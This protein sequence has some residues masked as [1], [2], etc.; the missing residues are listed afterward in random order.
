MSCVE[1]LLDWVFYMEIK[2][3]FGNAV[4]EFV[5]AP[6]GE[7][8]EARL[9]VKEDDKSVLFL[10][11]WVQVHD[12]LAALENKEKFTVEAGSLLWNGETLFVEQGGCS[13]EIPMNEEE[14]GMFGQLAFYRSIDPY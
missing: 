2:H 5:P 7:N 12:I 13:I 6:F 9:S 4:I 1:G 3:G 10:L 14:F 11:S 8:N